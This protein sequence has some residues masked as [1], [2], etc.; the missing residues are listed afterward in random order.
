MEF[1][2]N[3]KKGTFWHQIWEIFVNKNAINSNIR[4]GTF[5]HFLLLQWHFLALF[6]LM[7]GIF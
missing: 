5:W 3:F 2:C 1:S 4:D 7:H 6:G